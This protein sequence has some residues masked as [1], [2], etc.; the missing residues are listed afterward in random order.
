M[1]SSYKYVKKWREKNPDRVR[2]YNRAYIEKHRLE[3]SEKR[4]QRYL[5]SKQNERGTD[6]DTIREVPE[7][8][9]TQG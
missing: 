5:R 6:A 8:E 9:S 4:R 3:L 1:K 2:E 7:T